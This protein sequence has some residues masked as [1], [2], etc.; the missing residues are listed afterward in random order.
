LIN[1][2]PPVIAGGVFGAL[3]GINFVLVYS[4]ARIVISTERRARA[5]FIALVAAIIGMSGPKLLEE[6][7]GTNGDITVSILVL[8]GLLAICAA[9]RNGSESRNAGFALS[10][11]LLGASAGLKLTCVV[12]A[13][14]LTLALGVLWPWLRFRL[15]A[16][17]LYWL[18]GLAGFALAG[19]L[20]HWFLWRTYANPVF[21]FF[22]NAI[23]SPWAISHDFHDNTHV[24]HSV[25]E[26]FSYPFQELIGI[27]Y[28][29]SD[30]PMRDARFALLCAIAAVTAMLALWR[31]VR[32]TAFEERTLSLLVKRTPFAILALFSLFSYILWLHT[33]AIQRY[34]MPVAL[35]SG[36]MLFMLIDRTIASVSWKT[37]TFASL[38]L[39]CVLWTRTYPWQR[40]PYDEDWFG[41]RWSTAAS[42]PGTLFIMLG[43]VPIGYVVPFLPASAQAIHL[44]ANMPIDRST[45]LG[46]Q[47]YSMVARHEGPIRSLAV[48]AL[49]DADHLELMRFGLVVSSGACETSQSHIDRFESCPLE[50]LAG[51]TAK[52]GAR[53]HD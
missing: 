47:A 45:L 32:R 10:G 36:L 24:P 2:T 4:L 23:G 1:H 26:A 42:V 14:S 35:I 44:N 8:G 27:H 11:F 12:Y 53:L 50:R 29:T 41:V 43:N 34:L 13:A 19:G 51:A 38:A 20:W 22:N 40:L 46:K 52:S 48:T 16:L 25:V 30:A 39:F 9:S 33:F 21:P 28:P 15:S 7:G 49:S 18:G 3:A 17:V 31:S 5:M 37:Y 6:L